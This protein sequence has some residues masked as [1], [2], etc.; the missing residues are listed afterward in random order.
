[1]QYMEGFGV[2]R[3]EGEDGVGVGVGGKLGQRGWRGWLAVREQCCGGV[4][5][6]MSD[7]SRNQNVLSSCILMSLDVAGEIGSLLIYSIYFVFF[8]LFI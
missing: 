3:V 4:G 8:A 6:L 7:S 5:G 2:E 1:M